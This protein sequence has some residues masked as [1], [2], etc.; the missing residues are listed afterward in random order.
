[1]GFA[2]SGLP[3]ASS[4]S[5][6]PPVLMPGINPISTTL[7]LTTTAPSAVAPLDFQQPGPLF[8]IFALTGCF[9]VALLAFIRRHKAAR[10]AALVWTAAGLVV[11]LGSCGGGSSTPPGG[12]GGGT[13]P[14][15]SSIT[16]TATSATSHTTALTINV[17]P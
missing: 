6:S 14:G 13:P 2:C 8:L 7:T 17:T 12:G 16:V 4:C 9:S 11:L 3:A 1:V 5:F 15:A 10:K